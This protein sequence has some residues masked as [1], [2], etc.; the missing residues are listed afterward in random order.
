MAA[1]ASHGRTSREGAWHRQR[2]PRRT[3]PTTEMNGTCR[4]HS[5]SLRCAARRKSEGRQW[6]LGVPSQGSTHAV[7]ELPSHAE[8]AQRTRGRAKALAGREPASLLGRNRREAGHKRH[9]NLACGSLIRL[10]AV[11]MFMN[12]EASL[13]DGKEQNKQLEIQRELADVVE[14]GWTLASRVTGDHNKRRQLYAPTSQLVATL[15]KLVAISNMNVATRPA[16]GEEHGMQLDKRRRTTRVTTRR[17]GWL[18]GEAVEVRH[19]RSH[20][21]A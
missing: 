13:G 12:V 4:E 11:V 15:N 16:D 10:L 20:P 1:L 19:G 18:D 9:K 2:E 17:D 21:H 5:E 8:C 7:P 14:R 3:R 6:A